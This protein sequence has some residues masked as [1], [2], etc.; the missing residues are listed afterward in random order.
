MLWLGKAIGPTRQVVVHG[1]RKVAPLLTMTM[2]AYKLTR[3]RSLAELRP[4]YGQ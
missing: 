2:A 4:E 1:L 3:L